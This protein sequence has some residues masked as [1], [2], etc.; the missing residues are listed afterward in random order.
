MQLLNA[1]SR[2]EYATILAMSCGSIL[3]W[4]EVF[5]YVYWSPVISKLFFGSNSESMNL[6]N[7]L[8]IFL[9]GF[10]AR[11][12]GGVLFGRIGDLMGRKYS[13]ILS[14]VILI[15]PTFITG[16][17]PTYEQIG[18]FA[19]ISFAIL[20]FLQ[21]LPS[22]GELPGSFCYL[23]EWA[24]PKRKRYMMSWGAVGSQVGIAIS[25]IESKFVESILSPGDLLNWGWRI[26]FIF[27]SFIALLG[28]FLRTRL[29]ETP[30]YQEMERRHN[31]SKKSIFQI[32]AD[33]YR[34]IGM[35]IVLCLLT[36]SGFYILCVTFPVYVSSVFNIGQNSLLAGL[37]V[38]LLGSIFIP[39]FGFLG[40]RFSNKK[41]LIGSTVSIILL[42]YPLF[43]TTAHLYKTSSAI[44]L[45]AFIVCLSALM[46]LMPYRFAVLFP[47][48]VRFTG[49]GISFNIVDGV[50]GSLSTVL[51][52]YFMNQ[53]DSLFP[54]YF[55]LFLCAILSLG[56]LLTL[57]EKDEKY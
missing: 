56:A 46:A 14:I 26:S 36:S 23:Y 57:D 35:G 51:A 4:Y 30:S 27:G 42:L 3:E 21:V 2:K 34:A 39:F 28:F 32:I 33:Y 37:G 18:I 47:T 13:L 6:L 16:L 29:H 40:D 44:L 41:I 20:R 55:I 24:S 52:S 17:L 9:V 12:I 19:P 45:I 31:K 11:P 49:V 25:F 10:W 53:F 5:L 15:F 8:F 48:P 50:L 38:L 7:S 1:T 22:G 43:F 54:C